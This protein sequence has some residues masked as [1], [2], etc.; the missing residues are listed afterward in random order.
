MP[1]SRQGKGGI[2]LATYTA[3]YGLHQWEASDNFLRTDFNTD[4]Q[5]IDA[6]LAGKAEI[7]A[8]T[9]TGDGTASRTI[10]LGRTPDAVLVIDWYGNINSGYLTYGGLALEGRPCFKSSDPAL[11]L[12]DGGFTVAYKQQ[13]VS[14]FVATNYDGHTYYYLAFFL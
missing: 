1:L 4:Y 8:G 13:S 11:A 14:N 5:L 7:V 10:D 6:A 9:Y 2:D 12:V 3:N